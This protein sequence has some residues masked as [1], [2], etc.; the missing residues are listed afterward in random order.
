MLF[1][2]IEEQNE[3]VK[4]RIDDKLNNRSINCK[5]SELYLELV[6][7]ENF[8]MKLDWLKEE[9]EYIKRWDLYKNKLCVHWFRGR[10]IDTNHG[11]DQ[12]AYDKA[13]SFG[14][15]SI[16]ITEYQIPLEQET[17]DY[18][19]NKNETYGIFTTDFTPDKTLKPS[20]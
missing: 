10:N 20:H 9:V 11:Y 19:Y 7:I 8:C 13:T 2:Y 15:N 14:E 1:A 16:L 3:D 17:A 18:I 12:V 6:G 5:V 4:V